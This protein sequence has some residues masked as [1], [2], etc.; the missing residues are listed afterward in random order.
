[1]HPDRPKVATVDEY[2]ALFPVPVQE[3][4]SAV[5]EIIKETTPEAEEV[6]SYAIPAYKFHGMLIYF[7]AYTSHLSLSFT[8]GGLMEAFREELSAYKTSKSTIQLPFD[9]PIPEA[10]IKKMIMFKMKENIN[11]EAQKTQK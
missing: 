5:R 11:N 10:L 4:L 3:K 6:I 2:I 9:Q 8:P 1:M 7:S